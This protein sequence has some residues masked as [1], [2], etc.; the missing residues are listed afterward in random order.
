MG[1]ISGIVC[2]C[3]MLAAATIGNAAVITYISPGDFTGTYGFQPTAWF[4]DGTATLA[5][6]GFDTSLGTLTKVTI[7]ATGSA[8]GTYQIQNTGITTANFTYYSS[9][10][11]MGLVKTNAATPY[12]SGIFPF[13]GLVNTKVFTTLRPS[14]FEIEG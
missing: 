11:S 8:Y 1:K 12:S 14:L 13:S 10:M 9:V 5:V 4:D 3:A 2:T 6:K 7:E